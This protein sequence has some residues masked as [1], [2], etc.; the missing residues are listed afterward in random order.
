VSLTPDSP[1]EVLSSP[2]LCTRQC[3]PLTYPAH[4]VHTIQVLSQLTRRW[5]LTGHG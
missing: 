3:Q 2:S 1:R 5:T 4:G